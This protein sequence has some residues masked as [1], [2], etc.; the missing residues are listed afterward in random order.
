MKDYYTP[1]CLANYFIDNLKSVDN[2][3]LNKL[4][5]ISYGFAL[6]CFDEELELFKEPIQAWRLGPVIPSI[7]HEF[8]HYGYG[9]IKSRSYFYDP[10]QE[11]KIYFSIAEDDKKTHEVLEAVK[12]NYGS[13]PIAE[14]IGRTHNENTPWHNNYKEGFYNKTI[15]KKDIKKYY[16]KLL[17]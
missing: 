8:K 12:S 6:V 4:I 7:Y 15:P 2:L 14:L 13:L 16:A 17:N 3:R 10:M 9:V 11:K 5:Y 1:S